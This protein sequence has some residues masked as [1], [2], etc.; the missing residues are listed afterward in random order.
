MPWLLKFRSHT[1]CEPVEFMPVKREMLLTCLGSRTDVLFTRKSITQKKKIPD[2]LEQS[3]NNKKKIGTMFMH[4]CEI[5]LNCLLYYMHG[6][7]VSCFPVFYSCT[8]NPWDSAACFWIHRYTLL[9][10]L[11][12]C[13][14]GASGFLCVLQN[15]QNYLHF[16]CERMPAH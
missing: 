12:H 15:K 5:F 16:V 9:M 1:W 13:L 7:R 14:S 11:E 2:F 8:G 3:N 6:A 4:C 10:I